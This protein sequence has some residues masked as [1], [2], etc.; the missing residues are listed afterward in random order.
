V[1]SEMCIRDRAEKLL[2]ENGAKLADG[3]RTSLEGLIR[4]LRTAH[5]NKDVASIDRLMPQLSTELQRAGQSLYETGNT[6]NQKADGQAT[7]VIYE[8][9]PD[10]KN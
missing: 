1:G 10:Q 2:R 8:E 9:V 4:D 7:E 5:Q 3:V 6:P